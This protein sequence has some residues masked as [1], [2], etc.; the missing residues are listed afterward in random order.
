MAE[1]Q[2][3][4]TKEPTSLMTPREVADYLRRPVASVYELV[5]QRKLVAVKDGRRY[6]FRPCDVSAYVFDNLLLPTKQ[7]S[8][9][10]NTSPD[11]PMPRVNPGQTGE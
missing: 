5:R 1:M 4:A 7:S 3:P 10:K 11:N 8:L 2:C 9:R 6:K